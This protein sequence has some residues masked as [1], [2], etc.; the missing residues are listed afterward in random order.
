[1]DTP[2]GVKEFYT[3]LLVFARVGGLMVT[4]P[5]LGN[6]A[7]PGMAKAGFAAVFALA[8]TPLA[9]PHA[10][11]IPDHLLIMAG[12]VITDVMFG[13]AL[14]YLARVLFAAIEMAGWVID[15][16][17]GFG[18]INLLD[19]FSEQ[20]ASIMSMFQYQ[21]AITLYL[22]MNGHLVLLGALADSFQA[23]PPGA[24]SPQGSFGLTIMPI[25]Q[26][27]FGLGFRLA[28]PAAGVLFVMDVAFGLIARFVPQVNVFI[29]GSP[30]KIIIGLT[31]VALLLPT[32]AIAV[33]QIVA[34]TQVGMGALIA[35]SK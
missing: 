27:M 30:A 18:I 33:G 7:I 34:G 10:G 24:V 6:K 26:T 14:G 28:L 8:V 5:L 11:P 22:L 23:L 29:V 13:L 2:I 9:L 17:M 4:A 31:T 19:P 32:L 12:Q 3:F 21:L 35:G 25:L 1:M 15:T 20:Q 16:Q